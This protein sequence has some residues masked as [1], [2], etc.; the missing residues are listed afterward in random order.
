MLQKWRKA[1]RNKHKWLDGTT[2]KP[3]IEGNFNFDCNQV[4]MTTRMIL[5]EYFKIA[6]HICSWSE[7]TVHLQGRMVASAGQPFCSSEAAATARR[8]WSHRHH[9][10]V[11]IILTRVP[12]I[13]N[14]TPHICIPRSQP[15]D[16]VLLFILYYHMRCWFDPRLGRNFRPVYIGVKH[17]L[18]H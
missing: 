5:K 9:F 4:V 7:R 2:M 1:Y 11:H 14:K 6:Y 15:R 12:S 16:H 8:S 18:L 10:M 17:G 3:E 13:C